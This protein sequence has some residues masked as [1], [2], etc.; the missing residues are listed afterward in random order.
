MATLINEYSKKIWC[1]KEPWKTVEMPV[2][3]YK[4]DV[5][6]FPSSLGCDFADGSETCGKCALAACKDF[7]KEVE[8]TT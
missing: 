5:G 8:G 3:L 6:Y 1:A 2:Q 4:D 7:A